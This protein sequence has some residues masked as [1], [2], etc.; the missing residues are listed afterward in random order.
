MRFIVFFVDSL[1]GLFHALVALAG[2]HPSVGAG[3]KQI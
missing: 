2:F 3:A 1:V